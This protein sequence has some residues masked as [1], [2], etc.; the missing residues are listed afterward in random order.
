MTSI[1]NPAGRLKSLLDKGRGIDKATRLSQAWAQ[2]LEV[3][4]KDKS[5]LL[6]HIGSLL[7][8]PAD[9]RK[10]VTSLPE[11]DHSVYLRWMPKV[12]KAFGILNLD[13]KWEQFYQHFTPEVM[14]GLD[15]CSEVLS[16]QAGQAELDEGQLT[17]LLEDV[18]SLLKELH[19]SDLPADLRER[20]AMHL[21]AVEDA[22]KEYR[23]RGS[24][25]VEAEVERLIGAVVRDPR[26]W[27]ET[28][29]TSAGEKFWLYMGRVAMLLAISVSAV[30]IGKDVVHVLPMS[31]HEEVINDGG[32]NED[33]PAETEQEA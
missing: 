18:S 13:M 17:K 28:R 16:R 3:D 9:V 2:I 19:S 15:V 10:E 27:K 5:T 31:T 4:P 8:L 33:E 24:R 11:L 20:L 1:N 32:D 29:K 14:F 22:L 12:E 21:V 23:I 30:Q 6:K 7:A 26:L 25:P